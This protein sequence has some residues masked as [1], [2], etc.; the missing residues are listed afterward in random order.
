MTIRRAALALCAT[1]VVVG[2]AGCGS[3]GVRATADTPQV[4]AESVT[5]TSEPS[6]TTTSEPSVTTTSELPLDTQLSLVE[7]TTDPGIVRTRLTLATLVSAALNAPDDTTVAVGVSGSGL[8]VGVVPG[9]P[10]EAVRQRALTA[11]Q[12][13]V[14][15]HPELA[16]YGDLSVVEM[17]P[18]IN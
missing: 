16:G 9:T 7:Q 4:Q 13:E 14:A 3:N 15:R 12:A 2:G 18:L 6:A 11:I 5:T 8:V 10:A 1:V 17:P